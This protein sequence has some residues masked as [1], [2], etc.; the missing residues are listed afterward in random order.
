MEIAKDYYAILGV[1]RGASGEEVKLAY[2]RLAQRFHPDIS[3][4]PYAEERFKEVVEAYEAL[5]AMLERGIAPSGVG[6]NPY[7]DWPDWQGGTGAPQRPGDDQ[8]SARRSRPESESTEPMPGEDYGITV[9]ISLEHVVGGARV[10][11]GYDVTERGRDGALRNA[12]RDIKVQVPKG[13]RHGEEICVRGQGGPG[14]WGGPAGDLYVTVNLAR[15]RVFKLLGDDLEMRLP[16]APWE[17]ALG[18]KIKVPTLDG[19]VPVKVP[20]GTQSGA[21]LLVPARGLPTRDG[22]RGDLFLAVSIVVPKRAASLVERR[23]YEQLARI[24]NF[25]PRRDVE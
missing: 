23:I 22:K 6:A 8:R 9:D 13:V 16:L 5:S 20:P 1:N 17:A 12:R 15:H 7:S 10:S 14:H 2:R 25:N 4:E 3:K 19:D 24:S 21:Q 18:A 11:V